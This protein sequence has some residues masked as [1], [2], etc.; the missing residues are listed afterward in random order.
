MT[1][2]EFVERVRRLGRE[3]GVPVRLDLVRGKGSHARLRFGD[4]ATIVKDR[5]KE[6]GVGLLSKMLR[7]LGLDRDDI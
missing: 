6:I 7:D 5:R 2:R 4:R 1:G 3:R